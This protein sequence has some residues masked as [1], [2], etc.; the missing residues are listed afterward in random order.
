MVNTRLFT[1]LTKFHVNILPVT[2]MV[3]SNMLYNGECVKFWVTSISSRQDLAIY[4]HV[5]NSIHVHL[6][7]WYAVV[8]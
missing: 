6:H 5:I 1:Y 8:C 2:R 4:R 3:I 7:K